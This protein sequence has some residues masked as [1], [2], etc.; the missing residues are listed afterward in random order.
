[1]RRTP[2]K[3]TTSLL[4]CVR[5]KR[6]R[7][8]TADMSRPI[9]FSASRERA[10]TMPEPSSSVTTA[11]AGSVRAGSMMRSS[12]RSRTEALTTATS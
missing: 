10:T 1:M 5:S 8:N 7:S 12:W 6:A 11:S 2:S 3:P 4:P 9:H